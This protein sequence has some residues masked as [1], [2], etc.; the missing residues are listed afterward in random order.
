MELAS[1][2]RII[3]SVW[4]QTIGSAELVGILRAFHG[5]IV[6]HIRANEPGS[7]AYE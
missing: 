7:L 4:C 6:A 1:V 3:L 2:G 5:I